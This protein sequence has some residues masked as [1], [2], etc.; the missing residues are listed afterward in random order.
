MTTPA[1]YANRFN[2]PRTQTAAAEP[3]KPA[4]NMVERKDPKHIQFGDG[5]TVTGILVGIERIPM[6]GKNVCRYTVEELESGEILAFLG[7]YQIDSK[8]RLADVGHVVTVRCE[9]ASK[10]V[11]K[12]GN[13]MK[14]FKVAVSDRKAPGWAHDG[15]EITESDIGF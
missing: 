13:A 1:N 15:T 12:N 4:F 8:L 9:G 2:Q 7:T 11:S 3:A 10:E 5:E 14:L 6:N